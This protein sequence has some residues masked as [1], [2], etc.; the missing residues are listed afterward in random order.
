MPR[1]AAAP[2][3]YR[4]KKPKRI[5]P[6]I[7]SAPPLDK[8]A[9]GEILTGFIGDQPASDLEERFANAL[10]KLGAQFQ[11]RVQIMPGENPYFL[12]GR[13]RNQTGAVE[14]DFLIQQN[15]IIFPVQIDG[16]YSHKTAEQLERDKVQDQRLNDSFRQ[17]GAFPVKRI[18]W[19]EIQNPEQA[20]ELAGEI[21]I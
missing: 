15:G 9:D 3:G 12:S 8:Q 17:Y 14:I 19:D 18:R 4:Y 7:P 2:K 10:R 13:G 20:D 11:F 1:A 16:E 21:M 6:T 5:A